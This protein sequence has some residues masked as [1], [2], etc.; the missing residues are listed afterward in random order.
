MRPRLTQPRLA[1][2]C[3]SSMV[4]TLAAWSLA[5][6]NA[7]GIDGTSNI[8]LDEADPRAVMTRIDW[9]GLKPG[10][11]Q[12]RVGDTLFLAS[13]PKNTAGVP[14]KSNVRQTVSDTAVLRGVPRG[15]CEG[16][17]AICTYVGGVVGSVVVTAQTT[18]GTTSTGQPVT[19]TL[20]VVVAAR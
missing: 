2:V 13:T 15:I 3:R 14:V 19:S 20:V 1:L 5:S 9:I 17:I 10:T 11:V 8:F 12:V 16:T 18:G 6:C 4:V 7:P